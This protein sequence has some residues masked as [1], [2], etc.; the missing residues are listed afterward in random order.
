MR[1]KINCA[2]SRER[3]SAQL[4]SLCGVRLRKETVFF[5]EK[6]NVWLLS[7]AAANDNGLRRTR[8]ARLRV[9]YISYSISKPI[10]F[11]DLLTRNRH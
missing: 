1:R 7:A 3:T 6:N 11:R 9:R 10:A 2:E 8:L 5:I 4:L